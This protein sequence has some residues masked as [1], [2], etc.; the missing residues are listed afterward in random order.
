[1]KKLFKA[2]KQN[3]FE[4]VQRIIEKNPEL[5]N[6]VSKAP[7]KKDD[8]QSALQVAIKNGGG[9][10]DTRIISY[11][12]D[13]GA[14]VN[15]MED[16][17]G[18]KPQEIACY[19]VLMDMVYAV[20][21][22]MTPLH[23]HYNSEDAKN[24]A[25]EFSAVFERMLDLGADPNKTNN[26]IT[27]VW[28]CVVHEVYAH[29][30]K[31]NCKESWEEDYNAFVTGIANR[32]MDMM[33]AHGLDIYS[34]IPFPKDDLRYER[35]YPF[36]HY[37]QILRNNLIFNRELSYGSEQYPYAY[38]SEPL[39]VHFLRPYYATDNPYYGEV[40]SEERKQFFQKLK[41]IMDMIEKEE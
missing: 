38:D 28:L 23:F 18:L 17:K 21:T 33:L 24:K 1:M 3:D 27:P 39:W 41:E 22:N 5:V 37:S 32:M 4:E 13:K 31:G 2:I 6:C 20:C 25:N 11:L 36:H 7:P 30:Y 34:P 9:W 29:H 40:V 10:H 26:R 14:D 12:L 15:F 16:D 35:L 19:P 8:G